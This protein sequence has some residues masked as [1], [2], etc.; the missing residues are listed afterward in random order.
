MCLISGI[1]DVPVRS[2]AKIIVTLLLLAQIAHAGDWPQWL[3]PTHDCHAATN[4]TLNRLLSE[5]KIIWRKS[6]G[7]GFS[8]PVI[9]GRKL[10][11]FDEDGTDEV[12]HQLDADTG[13][14]IWKVPIGAVYKDE[15]SAGPRS[16][17]II[18]D[19]R[20]YVQSCKGEFR[21]LD[22]PTGKVQWGFSFE[23]D[24]GVKF[25]GSKA[26]EGTAARRGN[27]GTGAVDGDAVIVPVGS[28]NNATIV[29][30]D[31]KTGKRLWQT[32]TDE[33]A[34]SSIQVADIAGVRQVILL[35][36]DAL[37]GVD[38]KEGKLLWRLPLRTD[39]KRHA[40]T[41]VIDHDTIIV[42]S[43]TFGL[44]SIRVERGDSGIRAVRAW[45]NPQLK[46]NLSTPVLVGGFLYSQGPTR[47]YI[48]ADAKTGALK[49][50]APR[51]GKENSS[52]IA[53]GTNLL[54][55]TDAG[56]LVLI[57]ANPTAY[58]ELGRE[59]VCGKNWNFPA[60]ADGK[61]YVRDSRELLCL[62][63]R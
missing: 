3:G 18:D 43:H 11:Y 14:E 9:S 51:F 31:K 37:I 61:L 2:V 20:V 29:C 35:D 1:R 36:A 28:T 56:E 10:V 33:A 62:D 48:C 42:N 23:K 45:T 40:A 24:F 27:N 32:G 26:R 52:T 53:V 54:V 55:L 60:Y 47:N 59:Q 4:S 30:F 21:C 50:E 39:A 15:W 16:T 46:I 5:P 22:F 41:P 34:Y 17:P 49:W 44:A 57:A 6:I 8:S 38:R 58:K 13:K 25:L 12:A 63:L 7:G 19:D